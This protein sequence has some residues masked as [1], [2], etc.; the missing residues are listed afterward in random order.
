MPSGSA[1]S[2]KGRSRPR[3]LTQPSNRNDRMRAQG[4]RSRL[5]REA[6]SPAFAVSRFRT[7]S[8]LR[9][10]QAYIDHECL[11]AVG[12]IRE[13]ISLGVE[14]PDRLAECPIGDLAKATVELVVPIIA[15]EP[16]HQI[17][18][19]TVAFVDQILPLK[20]ILHG[21]FKLLVPAA[22]ALD[23]DADR[24]DGPD[25]VGRG[26]CHRD[27]RALT[28][29][30]AAPIAGLD[31]TLGRDALEVAV[32]V[33]ADE[34][35]EEVLVLGPGLASGT[36]VPKA[37][38]QRVPAGGEALLQT[39][40]GFQDELEQLGCI[41]DQVFLAVG[42]LVGF[43]LASWWLGRGALPMDVAI[44]GAMVGVPAFGAIVLS[45]E[46]HSVPMLIGATVAAGFGAGLFGHGTLTATMRSAPREQIGLSLGAWGAVQTTSA[47]IAIA[48]GGVLRDAVM[49]TS[50]S[51]TSAASGY[52][53]VFLLEA[54]LLTLALLLA[55]P[56]W[57]Q[58][59]VP[60]ENAI[61]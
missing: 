6:R 44:Y 23:D 2:T 48:V 51:G 3:P 29:T 49:M 41:A 7:L 17:Q 54:G 32:E 30:L 38:D 16:A 1:L 47:G 57:G 31:L 18:T 50:E 11:D 24:T 13:R 15:F 61:E 26:R 28:Q 34:I 42:S 14:L 39:P 22:L 43:G 12:T 19:V 8:G 53:Q 4:D 21:R 58:A 36:L 37:T 25:W 5:L 55:R 45:A 35:G 27:I 60:P 9:A 52:I 46:L 40:Q 10:G 20:L 56:I 59:G 33:V